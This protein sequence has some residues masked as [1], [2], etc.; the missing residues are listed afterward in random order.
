MQKAVVLQIGIETNHVS[1]SQGT[2]PVGEQ[3]DLIAV[4]MLTDY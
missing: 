4:T 1:E 3:S 2:L